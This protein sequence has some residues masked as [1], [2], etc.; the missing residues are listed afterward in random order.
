MSRRDQIKMTSD[1]VEA[2]LAGRRTMNLATYNHDGTI[3]LVAMWYGFLPDGTIGFETF[4]RSQKA[5]NLRRDPRV[6]ALV[7]AGDTY[8]SLQGVELVGTME[9]TD[10]RDTLLA[11][12]TS[13]LE[14]YH[15]EVPEADRAAAA[16]LVV[17]KRVAMLLRP[18][19]TVSWDHHKL[20]GT[21]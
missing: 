5:Q 13:V 18:E 17:R 7:E 4:A 14:R 20:G 19:R 2:F 12:A 11:I 3:H 1:E 15:P 6:T 9:L 21:Y 8:Q 16:E 10:D